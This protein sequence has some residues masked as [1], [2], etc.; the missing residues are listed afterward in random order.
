MMGFIPLGGAFFTYNITLTLG[1]CCAK[2]PIFLKIFLNLVSTYYAIFTLILAYI[3]RN[4]L[5]F[6]LN[7]II[8]P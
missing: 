3:I 1:M 4:F 8:V 5:K 7:F 2:D 6:E